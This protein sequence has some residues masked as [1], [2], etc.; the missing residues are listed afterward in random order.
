MRTHDWETLLDS[1]RGQALRFLEALPARKVE[2]SG[3]IDALLDGLGGPLPEEPSDPQAVVAQLAKAAD[4][5]LLASASGRFFG[6]V[7]GGA[8]PAA[9]GAEWLTAAW[10]QCAGFHALSPAAAVAEQVAGSWLVELLGLPSHA[11]VGFV[12]GTQMAHFVGLAAARHAVL[13]RTGWDVETDGLGGAPPL[14]VAVG[15][16]R[17]AT[18]DRALRF[19]GLGTSCLRQVEADAQGRM[20]PRALDELLR[21]LAGPALVCTQVG[22]VNSGAVDPVGEICEVAHDAG[23][24]VHVDGAF[25]LWAAASPALRPLLRGVERADSWATDAHKWLNVPYD[26]GIV[27]CA[28][29]KAHRAAMTAGGASYF[30]QAGKRDPVDWNPELSRRARGFAVW[31]ALRSLGRS[32]VADLVDRCCGLAQQFAAS[33]RQTRSVRVLNEV[34][35][36]QVLVRFEDDDDLTRRVIA[37]TQREGTCWVGGAT[38]Q[39]M[40][41]MRF[42]VSNWSTDEEDVNRAIEAIM[43]CYENERVERRR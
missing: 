6:Y 23:A 11:S 42:S 12:T 15:A 26:S 9:V 21:D 4:Q 22:N 10:D 25:G 30:P 43:R 29:P 34:V 14:T 3:T 5:G 27:I 36:N 37:A 41:V 31:A 13:G 8:V 28:D 39:R 32:G 16:E 40:Q 1:V 18:V 7:M 24:W 35:L 17:H 20:T 2:P 19:L 33:M 38:W